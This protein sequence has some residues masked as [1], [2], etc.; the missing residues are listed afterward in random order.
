MQWVARFSCWFRK[1]DKRER[2]RRDASLNRKREAGHV[3]WVVKFS[4]RS[5]VL[6][7]TEVRRLRRGFEEFE[8]GERGCPI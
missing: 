1:R 3:Q 5:K 4:C 2:E 7:K 8:E 6:R